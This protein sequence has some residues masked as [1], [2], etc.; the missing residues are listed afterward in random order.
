MNLQQTLKN[1]SQPSKKWQQKN[2]LHHKDLLMP[3]DALQKLLFPIERLGGIFEECPVR[4]LKKRKGI[5]F[6]A[7]H[8]V[9]D[10]RISAYPQEVTRQMLHTF[11]L[12]KGVITV[13]GKQNT[14]DITVVDVGVKGEKVKG[15]NIIT[16]KI[17]HG[18]ENFSKTHAMTKEEVVK[19]LE[20]GIKMADS[21]KKQNCDIALVGEMGIGNTTSASAITAVILGLAPQEVTGR[22][23]G[24]SEKIYNHKI[25]IIKNAL[26]KHNPKKDDPVDILEKVGGLE[27]AAMT[28]FLLGCA[29]NRI[30][31]LLDGFIT[32]SA[33]LLAHLFSKESISYCFASH[34]SKEQGHKKILEYLSLKPLLQL[35][36][37]LGEGSGAAVALPLLDSAIAIS[38]NTGTF[39]EMMVA[40][41]R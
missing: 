17:K 5:I 40:N 34:V 1:I 13:L 35:E 32:G 3:E 37:A 20:V 31:V 26:Q 12:Q 28:G 23:T 8:G 11:S 19:A 24:I 18:T 15:E 4:I 36:L 29:A 7:D 2:V 27:I 33:A 6:A 38:R 41:K 30:P 10:E 9:T 14:I 16:Q 25:T 39:S 21:L 22:G